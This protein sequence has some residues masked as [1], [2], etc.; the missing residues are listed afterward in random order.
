MD[1]QFSKYYN[2]LPEEAKQLYRKKL[3]LHLDGEKTVVLPDPFACTGIEWK[4]DPTKWPDL[5]FGDMY[6]FLIFTTGFELHLTLTVR[7][8]YGADKLYGGLAG[9]R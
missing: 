1:Y 8:H 5:Q 4:D 7:H 3:T 2:S 6:N 9:Y